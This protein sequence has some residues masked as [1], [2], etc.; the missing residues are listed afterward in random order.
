MELLIRTKVKEELRRIEEELR[1]AKREG[2]LNIQSLAIRSLSHSSS[3]SECA[4]RKSYNEKIQFAEMTIQ[5]INIT[6]TSIVEFLCRS[7]RCW[8]VKK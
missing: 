4:E 8:C 1:K 7:K 3:S 5:D 6:R 2:M